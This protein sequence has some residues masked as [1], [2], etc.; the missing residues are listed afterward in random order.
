MSTPVISA[1]NALNNPW[2]V[3]VITGLF[4]VSVV[5]RVAK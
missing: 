4:L 2:L 5:R 3:A 1:R